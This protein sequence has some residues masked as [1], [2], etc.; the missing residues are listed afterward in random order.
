M[1]HIFWLLLLFSFG[2]VRTYTLVIWN[3]ARWYIIYVTQPIYESR[4]NWVHDPAPPASRRATV[5]FSDT[6]WTLVIPLWTLVVPRYPPLLVHL[7]ELL[8][9]RHI[10]RSPGEGGEEGTAAQPIRIQRP[11][12]PPQWPRMSA[13]PIGIQ[14]PRE[15]PSLSQRPMTPLRWW[16]PQCTSI[17]ASTP[18][19][20]HSLPLQQPMKIQHPSLAWTAVKFQG[21]ISRPIQTPDRIWL[22]PLLEWTTQDLASPHLLC[23]NPAP[24]PS[25]DCL[26]GDKWLVLHERLGKL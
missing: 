16:V 15:R 10:P 20:C 7:Q 19:I 6:L 22:P 1:I 26:L 25:L 18:L 2:L 21:F 9:P 3:Y 12:Q 11:A 17:K 4:M 8:S 23:C 24:N 14:H 5:D 13:G